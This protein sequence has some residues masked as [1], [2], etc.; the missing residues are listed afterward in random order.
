MIR[1][2][3]EN[4]FVLSVAI[5][6]ELCNWYITNGTFLKSIGLDATDKNIYLV[7]ARSLSD[8]SIN[9]F[10][11]V[12]IKEDSGISAILDIEKLKSI[13]SEVIIN[14]GIRLNEANGMKSFRTNVNKYLSILRGLKNLYMT[15]G[16]HWD[17]FKDK[18][19]IRDIA[20]GVLKDD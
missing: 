7:T 5:F 8:I 14:I 13:D 9:K 3:K 11:V 1:I 18:N 20:M 4:E 2:N 10:Y 6:D 16:A 12:P 15:N 17:D 19:S